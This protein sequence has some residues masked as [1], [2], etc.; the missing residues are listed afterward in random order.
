[1]VD[2]ISVF[3]IPYPELGQKA[4]APGI[5]VWPDGAPRLGRPRS[6]YPQI[7]S[8]RLWRKQMAVDQ[9]VSIKQGKQMQE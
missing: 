2:P 5:K 4:D 7:G 3:A 1:M 6:L 8:Y 9:Q